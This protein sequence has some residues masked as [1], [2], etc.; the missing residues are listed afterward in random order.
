MN[1]IVDLNEGTALVVSDLHG[2]WAPYTMYRD[3]F[4]HL[5]DRGEAQYLI[6]LGDI[7]HGY[8]AE[9]DDA[10]VEMLLDIMRL[11]RELGQ[12]TVLMLLGNHELP[13]IYGITLSKG[14]INFT[15]RFEHALG[16][17]RDAIIEFLKSLPF[18][19]RTSNGV[20]L[21]HAGASALT[22]R[23]EA[24]D[25]LAEF[26][27]EKLLSEADALMR[28]DNVIDLVARML[29]IDEAT[30]AQAAQLSL[31]VT[32][33]DDPRYYHLLRG[34][35]ASNLEPEWSML[36]NFFFTRCEQDILIEEYADYVVE[37]LSTFS[38]DAPLKALVTGHISVRGGAAVIADRQ[39]RIASWAHAL[40]PEDGSFLYLDTSVPINDAYD[41][42]GFVYPIIEG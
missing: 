31:A 33:P 18:A 22:S 39:L 11:R 28:Q 34:V 1:R 10:S 4:L 25:L 5:L 3:Y 27:H 23:P 32:G 9:E 29:K 13:H 26:S 24:Q 16:K 8:G 40:P 21:T 20:M 30:Y 36:W 6:F 7:I 37:F 2:E 14:D 15:P 12:D 41:L 17:N 38:A 42:A 35:I 19:V